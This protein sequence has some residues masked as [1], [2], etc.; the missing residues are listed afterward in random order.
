VTLRP[1]SAGCVLFAARA[2]ALTLYFARPRRGFEEDFHRAKAQLR[3]T[4]DHRFAIDSL[5]VDEGTVGRGEIDEMPEGATP[6]KGRVGA[7]HAVVGNPHVVLGTPTDV[8]DRAFDGKLGALERAV[9]QHLESGQGQTAYATAPLGLRRT[10]DH[11]K[12]ELV[13]SNP[14]D[15]SLRKLLRTMNFGGVHEDAVRAA[16]RDDV[17]VKGGCDQRMLARY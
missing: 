6:E 5:A 3:D 12:A 9:T 2:G 14:D 4:L 8:N 10:G 1:L 13:V 15:V 16:V 7:G 17:S 11:L